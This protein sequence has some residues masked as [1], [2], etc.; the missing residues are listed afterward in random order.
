MNDLSEYYSKRA[1]EY[2]RIYNRDDPVRQAEQNK[3]AMEIKGIFPKRKILE[4]A[5]GTGYWTV[6]LSDVARR[7]TAIDVSDDVLE[8]ARA[9]RYRCPVDF[10]KLDAYKLPYERNAF[11]GGLANFWFSHIPKEKI[12][13]FLDGFHLVL[14]DD[15]PVFMTD[16][17]YNEG[18]GGELL[19]R[20]GDLNTYKIRILEND[21]KYEVLKNYYSKAQLQDIFGKYNKV[22]VFYGTCFWFVKYLI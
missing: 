2:E 18:V 14:M 17:V 9:K 21:E 8:I 13:S 16:N 11:D 10:Q 3:I 19:K 6:V 7:I 4:V 5:C 20:P 1:R 15:A 22:D 12:D